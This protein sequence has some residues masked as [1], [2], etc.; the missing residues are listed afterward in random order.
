MPSGSTQIPL[1]LTSHN[2]QSLFS[3]HYLDDILRRNNVWRSAVPQA[4]QFLTWLRDLYAQ[5]KAQLPLYNESQLEDKWFKPIFARLGHSSWEGQA[6]IPGWQGKVKKPDFV[7][8]PN[9]TARQTAVSQQNSR[10]YAQNALA[11]G[12]VKQWEINLSKKT[13]TQ[14]TFDNQNPMYQIDTYL[15]LTGLE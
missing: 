13:G 12:E 2:N 14:P 6:V 7:F 15:T 1:T 8:F 3:D 9:E 10:E 5:E 4:Q 11:V